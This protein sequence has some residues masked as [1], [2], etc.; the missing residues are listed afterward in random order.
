MVFLTTVCAGI[1]GLPN[2]G[3]STL[4]NVLT[5]GKA[6]IANFPFSTISPNV[7]SVTVPD[8]RLERLARATNV[9]I[10]TPAVVQFVD[11][12]GLVRGAHQGEGLG[13][14]FL[15][16]I[17]S[18][19]V[20]TEVVRCFQEEEIVHCEGSVDPI[21]DI[22]IIEL[23]L[24]LADLK[25]VSQKLV[26]GIQSGTSNVAEDKEELDILEKVKVELEKGNSLRNVAFAERVVQELVEE[27]FLSLKPLLYMA[28]IDESD[29]T[30]PSSCLQRLR[31]Y[32][33]TERIE[34]IEICAQLELELGDISQEERVEFLEELKIKETGVD[35][36]IREV[37]RKL[38]LVTFFT[39]TGGK[40]A[41]A[42][43]VE[44]GISA[45][46]AAG[47][48]HSDMERGYI[49]S[50]I[51]PVSELLQ[52]DAMKQAREKGNER[53]EGR[54]YLV[55]DGDVIQFRFSR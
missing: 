50:E 7:G 28:N 43:P 5:G 29:L 47:K 20:L 22:Q 44:R 55:Q 42:W 49:R 12:A 24:L 45:S 4:F 30:S 1:I 8:K 52:A 35:R 13:N 3:K 36:L 25:I 27:G 53:I 38:N 9:D 6:Q 17:R 32:A 34:I 16:R 2:V 39:V 31:K 51:I 21:R 14:E 26:K 19:S 23:E 11:V 54:D 15:S 33:S 41:K 40:E 48:V 37:Y 10:I 18:I 46:Q